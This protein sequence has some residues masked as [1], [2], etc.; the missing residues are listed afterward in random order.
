MVTFAP[1]IC[2]LVGI[3]GVAMYQ[4][5]RTRTG[6][7][8]WLLPIALVATALVQGFIL[9]AFPVW[10]HRLTLIIVG[11][12]ILIAVLLI[13]AR[14]APRFPRKVLASPLV[15]VGLLALLIAPTTWAV[16]PLR[17]GV[18]TVNPVAG[19]PQPVNI[20]ILLAHAF[21]PESA[22]AQPAL[23]QYLLAHQGQARYL[24]AGMNA[25]TVAPFILDTG[26][27][28]MALG[29]F[30]G[31]DQILTVQQ[32]A[33]MVQQGEV[34]F[35]LLP[36]FAHLQLNN[37]SPQVRKQIESFLQPRGSK[38]A[39]IVQPAISQWVNVRSG[40]TQCCRARNVWAERY[41]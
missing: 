3:G 4:A 35:F 12:S 14:L 37:V 8:S 20:L 36:S 17:S 9:A 2:A 21:I 22:H 5:Y 40:S 23:T 28:A 26:E 25:S 41:S 38:G 29:G 6:W 32:I 11:L 7:R 15:T 10:N 30:N 19:P 27:A 34:R 18:D 16:L 1:A 31:F 13:V 24:V 39:S 33:A